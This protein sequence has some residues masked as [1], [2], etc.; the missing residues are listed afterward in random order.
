V[1]LS[2]LL[3]LLAF[4]GDTTPLYLERKKQLDGTPFFCP[5]GRPPLDNT[6]QALSFVPGPDCRYNGPL[7]SVR[8]P[9]RLEPPF[10]NP[11]LRVQDISAMLSAA[12]VALGGD[13]RFTVAGEGFT[14]RAVN[15]K[16]LK[17]VLFHFGAFNSGWGPVFPS[18][19]ADRASGVFAFAKTFPT[20]FWANPHVEQE[21]AVLPWLQRTGRTHTALPLIPKCGDYGPLPHLLIVGDMHRGEDSIYFEAVVRKYNFS[22]VAL[23]LV[24]DKQSAMDTFLAAQDATSEEAPLASLTDGYPKDV[25]GPYHSLLRALKAKHTQIVVMDRVQAYFNFPYTDLGFNGLPLA[26]RNLVWASRLPAAWDKPA[27]LFAGRDHFLDLPSADFQD[28]ARARFPGLE[29]S[30]VNPMEVCPR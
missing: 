7:D 16:Y 15:Y 14:I 4:S 10:L 9:V 13:G 8:D 18:I 29:M 26:A 28:F 19:V 27:A 20:A 1:I 17:D 12:G 3:P 11:A 5:I 2:L 6:I 30:L 25:I 23:E 21:R 22:F 24:Q